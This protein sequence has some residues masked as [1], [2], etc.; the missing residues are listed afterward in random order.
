MRLRARLADVDQIIIE[1]IE[2]AL[3]GWFRKEGKIEK[4][5]DARLI[6]G[7]LAR[8]GLDRNLGNRERLKTDR[9]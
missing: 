2:P 9:G 6:A 8:T 7:S 3:P 4:R 1:L 5:A